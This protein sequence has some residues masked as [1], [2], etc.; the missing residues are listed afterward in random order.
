MNLLKKEDGIALVTS[1]MFTV[2]ALVMCMS[3]L[4]LVTTGAKSTGAL[5]R[6]R[7]S[8]EAAYGGT[9]ILVK[10]ILVSSFGFRDYSSTHP[11]T[12]FPVYLKSTMGSLASGA[13][14]SDCMRQRLTK[15]TKLWS[16]SCVQNNLNPKI[17][18]DIT[19]QLNAAN[20]TPFTVYSKIVDTME[21]HFDV[22]DGGTK[23]KVTIA[24]NSDTSSFVLEGGGTTEAGSVS[25]PHYP[26]V[27]KVEVQGERTQNASEKSNL[28]V[29]YAY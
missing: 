21:R 5:K 16:G 20:S 9:D 23:K 18:P 4:Y 27:Y 28:S 25:V 11:G 17:G 2:L 6:Y 7:T 1:L 15:P 19:F 10:D 22:L 24:G 3:L 13:T 8:I 12:T 26:Y 29:T 14:V